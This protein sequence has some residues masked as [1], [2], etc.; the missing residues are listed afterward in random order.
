M[1]FKCFYNLENMN[2]GKAV[3][4]AHRALDL[5]DRE[6]TH[7]LPNKVDFFLAYA[8]VPGY[9]FVVMLTCSWLMLQSLA[10]GL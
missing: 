8:T 2:E 1:F 4:M 6:A 3:P 7:I 5:E 10:T 9:R